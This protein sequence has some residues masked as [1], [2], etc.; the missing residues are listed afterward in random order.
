MVKK[1]MK[2]TQ[3]NPDGGIVER[4][5]PLHV[6]NVKKVDGGSAK[7]KKKDGAE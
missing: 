2:P 6:S 1:H 7:S 3:D 5:A 4:E